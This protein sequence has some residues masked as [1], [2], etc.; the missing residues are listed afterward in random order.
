METNLN[1]FKAPVPNISND[2]I[3]S[4]NNENKETKWKIIP[5]VVKGALT[6]PSISNTPISDALVIK[7]QE[8]PQKKLSIPMK[9]REILN[10]NTISSLIIGLCGIISVFNIKNIIKNLH[11]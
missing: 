7:K 10:L 3:V 8:I 2:N 1:T 4:K 9:K 6:V 11:H 5:S